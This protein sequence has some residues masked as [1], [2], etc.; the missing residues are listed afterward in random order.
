MIEI[1][2]SFGEG[3]GQ[4]LRSALALSIVTG[5]AITLT[6][7]RAKR[8]QP[9]LKPQHLM[10][11]RAAAEISAAKVEGAVLR[12][13][14]LRFEPQR[15]KPGRYQFEIGTAGSVGLVLQ[16]IFLPLSFASQ[17]SHLKIVG[18]T[19]VPWSPCYHYL[20]W[21]WLT[22]LSKIGYRADLKL[23][24]IGFYPRG[25]GVVRAVTY[26]SSELTPL[27]LVDRGTLQRVRGLSAV[28]ELDLAIARR[29]RERALFRLQTLGVP[30]DIELASFPSYSKGTFLLL[31]AD[32]EH[33]S[34]CCYALGAGGKPAETVADEAV[35]ALAANINSGAAIDDYLA[36]QLVL[37][38]SF[39]PQWSHFSTARITQHLLSNA[40]LARYFL[41][42]QIEVSG[43][44]GEKGDVRIKG[45]ERTAYPYQKLP[46]R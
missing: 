4:I 45:V 30:L 43:K 27:H 5:E 14:G 16:T 31:I 12:S 15:V 32:F 13:Q 18:G 42:V 26:P 11:V 37:P 17:T 19:H 1:D 9:G 28:A 21:H 2:A 7:I 20:A 6:R 22:T 29:Q 35:D 25:G 24:R 8:A 34:C 33:S 41:P 36:D 10:A 40:Q 46:S 44:E 38:L 3:G 23:E 39:V